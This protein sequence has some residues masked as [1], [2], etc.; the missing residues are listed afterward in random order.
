VGDLAQSWTISA[1]GLTYTFKLFEGVKFHD[2]SPLTSADVKAT[3]ERIAYPPEGVVSVRKERYAD[4][5]AIETPDPTTLVFRL[6]AVNASFPTLLA[7]PFNCIYSAAK[8]KQNP[9]YPDTEIMGS[10]AYQFVEHVR[11]SH[12]TAKRF[13]GYFR[14]GLPYIDGYKA[15][16]VK[17][18]AVV[19]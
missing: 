2:G 13:D 12:W 16:L 19:P 4:V 10:G 11:G 8:L 9:K 7:S 3:F 18:T 17:N 1:D 14:P 15:Y 6:K 5:A